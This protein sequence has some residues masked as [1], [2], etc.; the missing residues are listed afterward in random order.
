[1]VWLAAAFVVVWMNAPAG[2]GNGS[3]AGVPAR[4]P[5]VAVAST[6]SGGEAVS[7]AAGVVATPAPGPTLRVRL[8]KGEVADSEGVRVG[9]LAV[10]D[11]PVPRAVA[12][13]PGERQVWVYVAL[14]NGGTRDVTYTALDLEL[15][16]GRDF[17]SSVEARRGPGSMLKFGVLA[18][19][20]V[21]SGW[22]I[23]RVPAGAGPFHLLCSAGTGG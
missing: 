2:P 9:V 15:T 16:D 23:F 10:V 5:T 18:P 22:R 4:T 1:L 6:A 8:A 11:E 13:R 19:G 20:E 14:D 17:F 21:T 12:R 3:G 7:A